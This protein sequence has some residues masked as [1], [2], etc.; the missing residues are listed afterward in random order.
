MAAPAGSVRITKNMYA[1]EGSFKLEVRATDPKLEWDPNVSK[2]CEETAARIESFGKMYLGSITFQE[3]NK[4]QRSNAFSV[5]RSI[6]G[7]GGRANTVSIRLLSKEHRHVFMHLNSVPAA[8]ATIFDI[9]RV[10]QTLP[11]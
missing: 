8:G 11:R 1:Q 9:E 2:T 4:K 3:P 5:G 6:D 10:F 7:P